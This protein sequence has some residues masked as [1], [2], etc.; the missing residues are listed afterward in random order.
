MSAGSEARSTASR[1]GGTQCRQNT[2]Q[3]VSPGSQGP[4]V[5]P[6]L[7]HTQAPPGRHATLVSATMTGSRARQWI[8][9]PPQRTDQKYAAGSCRGAA[10]PSAKRIERKARRPPRAWRTDVSRLLPSAPLLHAPALDGHSRLAAE[11]R[12]MCKVAARRR[13]RGS[14]SLLDAARLDRRHQCRQSTAQGVSP[15]ARGE[16]TSYLYMSEEAPPVRHASRLRTTRGTAQGRSGPL[17]V[18]V[19]DGYG[20][21][22]VLEPEQLRGSARA[23]RGGVPMHAGENRC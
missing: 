20:N 4:P 3:G 7:T 2:A 17:G 22:A 1:F 6:F 5:S 9:P 15:G 10:G 11:P 21:A 14:P 18:V 16:Q 8:P 19:C 12:S 23:A 13:S